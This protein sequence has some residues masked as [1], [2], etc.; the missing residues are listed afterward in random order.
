LQQDEL[1]VTICAT[2][3]LYE[4]PDAT[5]MNTDEPECWQTVCL[6]NRSYRDR[7][8]QAIDAGTA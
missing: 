7:I 3:A 4:M 2:H 1:V 8:F 5:V 6:I